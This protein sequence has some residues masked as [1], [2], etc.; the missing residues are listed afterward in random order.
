MESDQPFATYAEEHNDASFS[1]WLRER[2][3]PAWNEATRHRFVEELGADTLDD[4]VFRRYLIQ[5]H[6]FL[7][8]GASVAGYAVGQAPTMAEKARL[9]EALTVLTG[10]ENEY[11][12]RSFDALSV[13]ETDRTDPSLMPTTR[14]FDD[15]M[16]RAALE[17]GYEETLAVTLAA[18]WVYISWARHVGDRSPAR[19]YLDEWIE[20][21]ANEEFEAYVRWLREQVDRYGPALSPRRQARVDARFGQVVESEVAF[22]DMAYEDG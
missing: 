17:G 1:A 11:F 2:S 20:I 4:R 18:E 19:F 22:F 21:H 15:L 8:T 9:T 7:E 6:V 14:A 10:S 13:P 5:D 16:M 12:E 3:E